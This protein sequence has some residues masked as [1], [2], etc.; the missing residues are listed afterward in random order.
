MGISEKIATMN[1]F[2]YGNLNY[3]P[4]AW[5]F[6]TCE[7]IKKIENIH[8]FFDDYET[9]YLIQLRKSGKVAMKIK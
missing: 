5:H 9:T 4:L 3:C 1:G 7:S 6:G 2:I 8:I